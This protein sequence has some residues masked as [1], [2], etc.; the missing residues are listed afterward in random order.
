MP[1]LFDAHSHIDLSAGDSGP[2]RPPAPEENDGDWRI[3][4]RLLCGVSPED[5]ERV[6]EA[7]ARPDV[8]PAFGLHPWEI[9]T[10]HPDWRRELADRLEKTPRAWLGEAG[11]D[12]VRVEDAPLA[13]QTDVL[14]YQLE[15]AKRLG[16][17]ASLHCV[18]A[19]EDLILLLDRHYA[20]GKDSP[21]VMHAFTGPAAYMKAFAERGAYF[22]IGFG[23]LRSNF[24]RQKEAAAAIPD[25]RLLIESDAYVSEDFAATGEL[26]AILR[27][28]A[29]IRRTSEH[30]LADLIMDNSRRLFLG[31]S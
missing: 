9:A 30:D 2:S 14:V 6:A 10:A 27:A 20:Q 15:L 18:R 21:F 5:W 4:G 11:L 1:D 29:D 16:R 31:Q 25:S 19:W 26:L 22:S 24:R 28:L 3:A 23:I 13:A 17:P 12:R 7:A 8:I